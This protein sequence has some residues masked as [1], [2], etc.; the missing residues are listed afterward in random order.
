MF[1]KTSAF[2]LTILVLSSAVGE[3]TASSPSGAPRPWEWKPAADYGGGPVRGA[4]AFAIGPAA[5]VVSG[6]KDDGKPE[7]QCWKYDPA[8]DRWTRLG[9]FP[10]T[11][12][13]E[14]TGF[15]V[16]GKGYVCAGSTN[17]RGPADPACWEYDPVVDH[18]TRK[19]DFPGGVR[20]GCVALV[21]G[22][23]TYIVGG[24]GISGSVPRDVWEYDPEADRW[25]RKADFP[26]EGRFMPSGFVAGDR[27]YLGLGSPGAFRFV[28]DFWEYDPRS[29]VWTR[30]R[31]FPGRPRAYAIGMSVGSLGDIGAGMVGFDQSSGTM[32][33]TRE[34]WEYD[35][36]S[37]SWTRKPDIAGPGRAMAVGF[38]LGTELYFGLGNDSENR[39]L[40]DFW[41]MD[42]LGAPPVVDLAERSRIHDRIRFSSESEY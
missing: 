33:L 35:P 28:K 23:K 7:H 19:A 22:R 34:V 21:I 29:D 17:G 25:I 41:R 20:S 26:G 31:D 1:G 40:A 27:G 39:T 10:G 4:M 14:G 15:S 8:A 37:D 2:F 5:Y 11:A 42:D 32:T 6:M 16:G 18:W 30:K 24:G 9:D 13:I 38:V 3:G 36:G 12:V